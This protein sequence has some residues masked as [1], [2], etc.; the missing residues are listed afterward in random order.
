M[1]R[2]PAVD[3]G[4]F[5]CLSIFI[6]VAASGH[7]LHIDLAYR[8]APVVGF[9][10]TRQFQ[11]IPARPP[12]ARRA[13]R[14]SWELHLSFSDRDALS[15]DHL[16]K[17]QHHHRDWE[18]QWYACVDV[19]HDHRKMVRFEHDHQRDTKAAF[20]KLTLKAFC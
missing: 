4:G 20:G 11:A 10:R 15:G 19:Q 13:E 5:N 17:E 1:Q 8:S 12:R 14:S 6:G 3:H 2:E 7:E 18:Q 9:D 16:P